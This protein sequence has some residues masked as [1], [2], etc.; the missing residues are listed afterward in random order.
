MA[1]RG[2]NIVY[3]IAAGDFIKIGITRDLQTRIDALKTGCPLA[4]VPQ[5]Y[6]VLESESDAREVERDA[7]KHFSKLK[8]RGE[9]FEGHA[10]RDAVQFISR[11][12]LVKC[13]K[14]REIKSESI[15]KFNPHRKTFAYVIACFNPI[16]SGRQP[17]EYLLPLD[18][19][20]PHAGNCV[21]VS[22]DKNEAKKIEI[23][24]VRHQGMSV[25]WLL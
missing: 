8:V 4:I 16:G 10:C 14:L 17:E 11:H 12:N 1:Y 15:R 5:Y 6:T 9:W 23:E 2:A 24:W 3:V 19:M 18:L 22:T 25:E 20:N 21:L 13:V 7:H